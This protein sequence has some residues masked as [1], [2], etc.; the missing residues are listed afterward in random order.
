LNVDLDHYVNPYLPPSPKHRLPAFLA[1][2]IGYRKHPAKNI[3]NVVVAW[4]ACVGGISSILLVEAVYRH[5]P[6][7][8][9][10]HPPIIISSLGATA[11][12]DYNTIQSPLAQP[13]AS[14]VGHTLSAV[15]GVGMTKL[16]KLNSH[17][18]SLRWV[19]GALACGTAS[20][21]MTLTDTIHPPG[22]ATALL[23]AIDPQ[24]SDM[25]WIFVVFVIIGS[26]LMLG[27]ALLLNNIQ[28]QFPIFWWT[29]KDVGR[30][31]IEDVE[32]LP[33]ANDDSDSGASKEEP[34]ESPKHPTGRSIVLDARHIVLPVG[35]PLS[36][37]EDEVLEILRGRLR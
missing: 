29:P 33:A 12:L 19:A 15:I 7:L 9:W 3:G 17:F 4:W 2:W 23:A 13:R 1:R 35:F 28:R 5:S 11:I 14:L 24:V 34:G 25:G 21:A 26:L 27:V 6:A 31:K 18:E 32:G 20:A 22:G 16:F 36:Q 8:Y 10:Y 37:E 30:R